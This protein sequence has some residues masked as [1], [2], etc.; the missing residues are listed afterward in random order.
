MQ[1]MLIPPIL[2]MVFAIALGVLWISERQRLAHLGL[3]ALGFGTFALGM[4]LQVLLLPPV[5]PA[6]LFAGG[7]MLFSLGILARSGVAG[8]PPALLT[9][10]TA[11]VVGI[12]CFRY[13]D[14]NLMARI[15]LLNFGLGAIFLY[16]AW[17]ARRLAG[18]SV[19]DRMLFWSTLLVGLHFFPRTLLTADSIT[20]SDLASFVG[21]SY[22]TSAVYASSIL[23]A[24]LGISV[25][26]AT[27]LD[28]TAALQADRDTDALTG[29]YN[30]R[31]LDLK[32]RALLGRTTSR[33]VTLIICD[34]DHFKRVNDQFGHHCGDEVLKA[35]AQTLRD[36]VRPDDLVAR[37]GGEE[38]VIL[39]PKMALGDGIGFAERVRTAVAT[40][41]L[42]H[43]APG[44]TVT[45]S[46]GMVEVRPGEEPWEAMRRADK[47]LYDAKSSGRNRTFCEQ[48][49]A[50]SP[51]GAAPP[52]T[53]RQ[54][55]QNAAR[56]ANV[57]PLRK[58]GRV[59]ARG[60]TPAVRA[61]QPV[62]RP[63]AGM[64]QKGE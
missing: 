5:I 26:F 64:P 29:L 54:L 36:C 35:F 33:P 4:L 12:W 50:A 27:I 20:G 48:R 57:V 16:P 44:L 11:V 49:E 38:F 7:T 55:L 60:R 2:I 46:L 19:A 17:R 41:D 10:T 23:S 62:A 21:S 6:T 22:W 56:P 51:D 32:M 9:L 18:G 63:D 58:P 37:I 59:P 39:V 30:R 13:L 31:G 8:V 45:C 42:C 24:T 15:Y 3:L 47:L 40:A 25:I 53:P 61:E 14:D 52:G 28:L 43:I 1:L 34:I